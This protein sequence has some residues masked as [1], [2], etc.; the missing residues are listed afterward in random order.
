MSGILI[1]LEALPLGAGWMGSV[2]YTVSCTA[3]AWRANDENSLRIVACA[4][5]ASL[6]AL[7]AGRPFRIT[8]M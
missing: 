7:D 3:V 5:L 8:L 4:L 1:A 6:S 2:G